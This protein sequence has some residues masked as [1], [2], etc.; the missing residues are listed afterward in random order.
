LIEHRSARETEELRA[1]KKQ[2]CEFASGCEIPCRTKPRPRRK[3]SLRGTLILWIKADVV[4]IKD[5]QDL[6]VMGWIVP[7]LFF[8]K[9]G[10]AKD[11][12]SLSLVPD[13]SLASSEIEFAKQ[14]I[15]EAG[16]L[17]PESLKNAIDS[18]VT[19][20]FVKLS[21]EKLEYPKRPG[22]ISNQKRHSIYGR[23]FGS[24]KRIEVNVD[25]L[26]LSRFAQNSRFS[27]GHGSFKSM[28]VATIIH[29]IAHIYDAKSKLSSEQ[30]YRSLANFDAK[31]SL[32][33]EDGKSTS[34]YLERSPDD[35][36]F[37]SPKESVA[38]NLEY[39]LLDPQ[40]GCR[41]PRL[42]QLFDER[43]KL[44]KATTTCMSSLQLPVE[45][46]LTPL[47]DLRSRPISEVHYL[48]A[49]KGAPTMSKW[50]HA[51]IRLVLCP[52]NMQNS[53]EG[54]LKC[55]MDERNSV[56]LS[57][58]AFVNTP[59]VNTWKGISGK[60]P[61][62]LSIQML[63]NTLDQYNLKD[64]RDLESYPL[65]LSRKE[66][67]V[68][69]QFVLE[70]YW[71]YSG[72]YRFFT[73]NCADEAV[74]VLR[75]VP[76]LNKILADGVLTPLGLKKKLLELG[77]STDEPLREREK[78]SREGY[79]FSGQHSV[80]EK[81]FIKLRELG[82]QTKENEVLDYLE[83]ISLEKRA[84]AYRENLKK[85]R[86]DPQRLFEWSVNHFILED[87]AQG[88][89]INQLIKEFY[90][91]DQKT[92]EDFFTFANSS[93]NIR[94]TRLVKGYGI[95]QNEDFGRPLGESKSL[96]T[97]NVSELAKLSAFLEVRSPD[98]AKRMKATSS[99][100]NFISK[101][102]EHAVSDL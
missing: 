16:D 93:E 59:V 32:K 82:L 66:M 90:K 89:E 52:E 80:L 33:I 23:A 85:L 91:K 9:S 96:V 45:S 86:G 68:L 36:E 92:F 50:G 47:I 11:N 76:R 84:L 25:F 67:E 28:A 70:Q 15:A 8:A 100:V 18:Q 88:N 14:L 95:P 22:H 83:K 2:V 72:S 51:M 20:K 98:F 60:Y 37:A 99:L 71:T 39:Y 27:W 12:F 17:L 56:V 101:E 55:R 78:A 46:A 24:K 102:L 87:Y 30:F 74:K 48:F 41:R 42:A 75:S 19:I 49:A 79:F 1:V 44:K 6:K 3:P 4:K 69:A 61:S 97:G 77:I 64:L 63:S 57:F 94:H 5:V 7:F 54:L 34:P 35:Y 65:K 29:E 21:S 13:K 58:A 43:F 53:E 73:N 81:A 26:R 10:L 40:Y 31:V 38:V 62:R